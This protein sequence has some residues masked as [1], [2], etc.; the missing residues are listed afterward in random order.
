M[1]ES[2]LNFRKKFLFRIPPALQR[3]P[4]ASLYY[5]SLASVRV[6]DSFSTKQ[7][8]TFKEQLFSPLQIFPCVKTEPYFFNGWHY[9][10]FFLLERV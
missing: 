2:T 9:V 4:A 5:N 8:S 6:Q 10:G 1:N 3:A 7:N